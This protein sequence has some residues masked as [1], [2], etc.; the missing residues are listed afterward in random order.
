MTGNKWPADSRTV[1]SPT[2][3]STGGSLPRL[4]VTGAAGRVGQVL[5]PRLSSRYRL[6]LTDLP[7]SA[8]DRLGPY[9]EI[10]PADLREPNRLHALF[11]GTDAVLHL[12]GT[13][14]RDSSWEQLHKAN[15]LCTYHAVAAARESGCGRFIYASSVHAV[16]GYGAEQEPL[17]PDLPPFPLD[18]YGLTKAFGELLTGVALASGGCLVV[19]LRLGAVAGAPAGEDVSRVRADL[20]DVAGSIDAAMRWPGP[21]SLVINAVNS[22]ARLARPN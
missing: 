4:L 7:S 1:G 11:G 13:G 15:V 2:G 8:L 10:R 14:R 12:A 6:R 5:V 17:S 16:A 3:A 21:G 22:D 18:G 20:D 19:I 9:G